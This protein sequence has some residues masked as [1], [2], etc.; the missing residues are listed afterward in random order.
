MLHDV[1]PTNGSTSTFSVASGEWLVKNVKS[2][3]IR[4]RWSKFYLYLNAGFYM[5]IGDG[6]DLLRRCPNSLI[7]R[8][9]EQL[10]SSMK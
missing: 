5:L 9:L 4:L 2:G 3:A 7:S 8:E 10:A 1:T 6:R